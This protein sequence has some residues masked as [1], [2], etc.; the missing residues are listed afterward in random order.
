VSRDKAVLRLRRLAAR[1]FGVAIGTPDD[2]A[3]R[4]CL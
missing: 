2:W 4:A 1:R 3:A